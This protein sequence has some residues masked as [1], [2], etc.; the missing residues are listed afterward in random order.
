LIGG[1]AVAAKHMNKNIRI[2]GVQAS[3]APAMYNKFHN[4]PKAHTIATIAEGI[5]VKEPGKRT[6]KI[7]HEYVD[8]IITVSDED[9]AASILYMLER[10]KTLIE[11]AGASAIAAL[12]AHNDQ[13]DSRHCGVIVSGGNID[14]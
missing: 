10:N 8:D 6:E 3:R 7:I 11:G 5:A 13:I 14:I 12:F 2:I 9:I 4:L 1:I